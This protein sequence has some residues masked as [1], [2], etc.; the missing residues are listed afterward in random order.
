M[1]PPKWLGRLRRRDE[2]VP[3]HPDGLK[4]VTC[5]SEM[6]RSTFV[7]SRPVTVGIRLSMF[8]GI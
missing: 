7:T 1:T 4:G 8:S 3:D 5:E 6:F 2:I